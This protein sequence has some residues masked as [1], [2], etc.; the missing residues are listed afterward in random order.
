MG[1]IDGQEGINITIPE[2]IRYRWSGGQEILVATEKKI[3]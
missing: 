1:H 2:G 3:I